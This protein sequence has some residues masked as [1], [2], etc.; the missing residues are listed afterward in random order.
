MSKTPR[1]FG[2]SWSILR[3]QRPITLVGGSFHWLLNSFATLMTRGCG[4]VLH[5][6]AGRRPRSCIHAV[7]LG[8][9]RFEVST[10]RESLLIGPV[11]WIVCPTIHK[12]HPVVANHLVDELAGQSTTPFL[13][14]AGEAARNFT[15]STVGFDPQPGTVGQGWQH[16]ASSFV[17]AKFRETLFSRLSDQEQV[18]IRS[19]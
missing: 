14:A 18:L 4:G 1:P 17:E 15:G 7:G 6:G 8:R 13:S 5:R 10:S 2:C 11:G 3:R 9:S 16:E 12:R 19:S